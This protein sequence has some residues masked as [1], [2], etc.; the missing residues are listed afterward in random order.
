VQSAENQYSVNELGIILI[1][2]ARFSL[3]GIGFRLELDTAMTSR[4]KIKE[5][6]LC[7][8]FGLTISFLYKPIMLVA[9]LSNDTLVGRDGGF[10]TDQPLESLSM[11]LFIYPFNMTSM[12]EYDLTLGFSP[13]TN[14]LISR[15]AILLF[16]VA[17]SSLYGMIPKK[18][19]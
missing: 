13:E 18:C 7:Y 1:L 15:Y 14:A 16:N 11:V 5:N 3:T 8:E 9:A 10:K 19:S 6:N 4:Q 17:K 12:S 2:R